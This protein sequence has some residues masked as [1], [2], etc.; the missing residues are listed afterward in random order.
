M[1]VRI[2][3]EGNK[4]FVDCLV[5]IEEWKHS[6]GINNHNFKNECWVNHSSHDTYS[7]AL[8]EKDA[9]WCGVEQA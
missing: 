1:K 7:E 6:L 2:K 9:L 4:Y 8:N 3:K 5:N